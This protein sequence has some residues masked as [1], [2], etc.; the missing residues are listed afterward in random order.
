MKAKVMVKEEDLVKVAEAE[1][2]LEEDK[3]FKA[4]MEVERT[5]QLK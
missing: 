2:D 3:T 1:E 5:K 4:T